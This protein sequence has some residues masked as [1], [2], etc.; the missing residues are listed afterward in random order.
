M[1]FRW[2]TW[3]WGSKNL[4]DLRG[5]RRAFFNPASFTTLMRLVLTVLSPSSYL[6]ALSPWRRPLSV[7]PWKLLLA[8]KLLLLRSPGMG[9]THLVPFPW[10]QTEL[11]HE[12]SPLALR[13]SAT[14]L[15]PWLWGPCG[16]WS[17]LIHVHLPST[18]H[19]VWQVVDGCWMRKHVWLIQLLFLHL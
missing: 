17:N 6:N 10:H 5:H 2:W 19:W 7:F 11:C 13:V 12:T 4:R 8:Q 1:R 15:P 16:Q 9:Q 14:S 3:T 18:K